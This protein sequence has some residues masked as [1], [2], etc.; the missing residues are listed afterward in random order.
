M[1][2]AY[3][4]QTHMTASTSA[5][6]ASPPSGP[7]ASTASRET[8]VTITASEAAA[9]VSTAAAASNTEVTDLFARG[10]SAASSA[11]AEAAAT[12][13]A[14]AATP[15][16][17]AAAATIAA[18]QL[19]TGLSHHRLTAA[20]PAASAAVSGSTC[21]S[22]PA[23]AG[24]A[25][26]DC[27]RD[28]VQQ[29]LFNHQPIPTAAGMQDDASVGIPASCRAQTAVATAV[30]HSCDMLSF[31]QAYSAQQR[32][33]RDASIAQVL[34]SL[35]HLPA[36]SNPGQQAGPAQL[37]SVSCSKLPQ[38]SEI[39]QQRSDSL[40]L[41][42]S[43]QQA[44]AVQLSCGELGE[45]PQAVCATQPLSP[46]STRQVT[47]QLSPGELSPLTRPVHAAQSSELQGV[48][49]PLSPTQ[50]RAATN[51]TLPS[52]S[53]CQ[54]FGVSDVRVSL[55]KM[56]MGITTGPMLSAGVVQST[57]GMALIPQL[58]LMQSSCTVCSLC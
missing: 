41:Q 55:P 14:A 49:Q 15:P 20:A 16:P 17:Q 54:L 33:G 26:A 13:T 42:A 50:L 7:A 47:Q 30:S 8:S 48:A 37:V 53:E 10:A 3:D 6:G 24:A 28:V 32:L 1:P 51:A 22:T 21:P 46:V 56:E 35:N 4:A 23:A 31:S 9:P 19:Q 11:P 5:R 18:E 27:G 34:A 36:Y 52:A 57:N 12:P 40:Q 45:L 44:V 43:P 2:Q 29:R 39:T 58:L 38:Q 25:A